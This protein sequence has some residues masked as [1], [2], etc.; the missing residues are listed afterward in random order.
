MPSLVGIGQVGIRGMRI[1]RVLHKSTTIDD[2]TDE[3]KPAEHQLGGFFLY[4]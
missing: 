4:N 3:K 1:R 2:H